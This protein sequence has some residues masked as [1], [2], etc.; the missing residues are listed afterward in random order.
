MLVED[1]TIATTKK[2]PRVPLTSLTGSVALT[3][4]FF[5]SE[6]EKTP[7]VKGHTYVIIIKAYVLL[8]DVGIYKMSSLL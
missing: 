6:A 1:K 5:V 3:V 2:I 4:R 8:M 7:W